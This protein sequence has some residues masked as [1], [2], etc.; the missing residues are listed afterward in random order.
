MAS[1]SFSGSRPPAC[2]IVS[3]PPPPPPT[4]SAALL[5]ISPGLDAALD[6]LGRDTGDQMDPPV[7]GGGEQDR[8]VRQAS[9]DPVENLEQLLRAGRLDRGQQDGH[10]VE[11]LGAAE[12]RVD[13][14]LAAAPLRRHPA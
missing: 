13:V 6:Q 12:Q 8:G 9:A 3:R 10:A 14:E 7:D 2:A 11:L 4:A 1:G 5:T